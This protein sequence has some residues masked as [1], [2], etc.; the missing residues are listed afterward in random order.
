MLSWYDRCVI[1]KKAFEVVL[2]LAALSLPLWAG[3]PLKDKEKDKRRT[4]VPEGGNWAAYTVVSG[5]TILAGLMLA[6]KQRATQ[7]ASIN[8]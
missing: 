7:T 1:V 4:A 3:S 6:R 8:S 2:V 5:A